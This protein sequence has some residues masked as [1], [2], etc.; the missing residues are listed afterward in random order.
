MSQF[1]GEND[2][3][4]V[5]ENIMEAQKEDQVVSHLE[6]KCENIDTV[7][8]SFASST[9]KDFEVNPIVIFYS[10]ACVKHNIANH[11]EQPARVK[12]ILDALREMNEKV[13]L[14]PCKKAARD[15]LLLFHTKRHVE[16][17]EAMNDRIQ[18][19]YKNNPRQVKDVCESIDSDT[20]MMRYTYNAALYAAGAACESVDLLFD[21][22]RYSQSP[23][24]LLSTPRSIFCCVRPPGHH[25]EPRRSMGFCFFN[26]VGI[27]AEYAIEQYHVK[28]VAILD[29]DVHHGNGTERFVLERN[30]NNFESLKEEQLQKSNNNNNN[31]NSTEETSGTTP[32]AIFYGSTHEQGAYP[33]TG[34]KTFSHYH[35]HNIAF[36]GG[37]NSRK[38]FREAWQTILLELQSFAPEL[39]IFSAGF[40]AHD[41]DPLADVELIDEDYYWITKEI[42]QQT[43]RNGQIL[44][45]F[46]VLEGGYNLEAIA[47]SSVQHVQALY[48]IYQTTPAVDTSDVATAPSITVET[49]SVVPGTTTEEIRSFGG[50]EVK[51]LQETLKELG[52]FHN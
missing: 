42:L 18:N 26:N 24:N 31:Y 40:D 1:V 13:V 38:A 7:E 20:V 43:Q 46:S 19:V 5:D 9:L 15:Q 25:A 11:P 29:F 16:V 50:D 4:L 6:S 44:P 14:L 32:A 8:S 33:G 35:I 28:R 52:I 37:P 21:L 17:L 12:Y 27:A 39:I 10:D 34:R 47:R 45:S 23:Y 48:D 41:D 2:S 51:A 36:P 22:E 49:A 3:Q 30:Q